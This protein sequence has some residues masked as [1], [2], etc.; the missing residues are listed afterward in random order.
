MGAGLQR[1]G[2]PRTP[3]IAAA[4]IGL[5]LFLP[6]PRAQDPP[7]QPAEA[8]QSEAAAPLAEAEHAAEVTAPAAP[9]P[10]A[11]AAPE[12][13][14][15][16]ASPHRSRLVGRAYLDRHRDVIGATVL[17]QEP[18]DPSRLYLT[19]SDAGGQFWIGDLPDGEYTV[20]FLR[21]GLLPVAKES[22][23]L[24]YPF[25]A[26][27]EVRMLP[28]PAGHGGFSGQFAPSKERGPDADRVLL[29]GAVRERGGTPV[30]QARIRFLDRSGGADPLMAETDEAGTF[31]FESVPA[32]TW[33]LEIA[34]VGYVPIRT[35]LDIVADTSF[36][37]GLVKQPPAYVPSPFE[38]MP[39]ERPV[40]PPSL[41]F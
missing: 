3:S 13:A 30:P 16:T 5:A 20:R 28:D 39:L 21:S 7:A 15:G 19:S 32:G 29:S 2:I 23:S 27:V 38:L 36:D 41:R 11:E 10:P 25:R 1:A 35:T 31:R 18:S 26:V 24:R 4:L 37:V 22:V 14:D 8:P 33:S 12:P 6:A 34:G 9:A 40:E 17:A